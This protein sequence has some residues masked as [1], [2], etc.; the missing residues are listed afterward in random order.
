MTSSRPSIP[1]ESALGLV[2]TRSFPAIVGVADNML[3]AAAV[4]LVGYEKIGSGYCTAVV[5]GGI[6]DVR[7]AIE[8]GVDFAEKTGQLVSRTI[9]PRPLANLNM[10]LP[11]SDRFS[12]LVSD[13]GYSRL[14]NQAVG[15]LE[16]RG[17]PAM[18]GAADAM[19]KAAEVYLSGYEIVG[20]GL[21]TVVVR[22]RV[23]DVAVAVEA[24][25]HEADRIGE[26]H[27][28]MVI[29]RPLDDLEDTLPTASCWIEQPIALPVEI[30]QTQKELASQEQR[31]EQRL[32]MPDLRQLPQ[33]LAAEPLEEPLRESLRE[34]LEEPARPV[35]EPL[36]ELLPLDEPQ[37][38]R[39]EQ[40]IEPIEQP[41][42]AM[43]LADL[44]LTDLEESDASAQSVDP[45]T[46]PIVRKP[47]KLPEESID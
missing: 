25:M 17:F 39:I 28:V 15:L 11:I 14:S 10:V 5:R 27:A 4:R 30:K 12:R 37:L 20:D 26:L 34:P 36:V 1:N 41:E 3:K 16:T 8:A 40:P 2:S 43:P 23:S 19:L 29:P 7:L 44:E 35:V 47:F 13:R 45:S 18:V 38:K 6:S 24:G 42:G 9:I 32:E 21:C 33:P 46:K 22:G 31:Q